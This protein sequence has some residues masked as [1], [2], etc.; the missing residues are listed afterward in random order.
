MNH[1]GLRIMP[2]RD[3]C[4]VQLFTGDSWAGRTGAEAAHHRLHHGL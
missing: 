1:D 4:G 3:D 2:R